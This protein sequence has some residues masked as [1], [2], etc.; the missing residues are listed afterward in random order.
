MNAGEFL[1]LTTAQQGIW[2]GQRLDPDSPAYNVGGYV[3]LRGVLDPGLLATACAVVSGEAETLRVRVEPGGERQVVLAEPGPGLSVVDVSG[4]PDPEAAASRSMRADL[5]RPSDPVREPV[6]VPVLYRLADHHHLWFVRCHHI[7]IDGYSFPLVCRRIAEVYTALARGAEPG[8]PPFAPLRLLVE[9]DL[10]YRESSERERDAGYWERTLAD[11]PPA[12]TLSGRRAAHTRAFTRHSTH[13]AD[14]AAAVLAGAAKASRTTWAEIAIAAFAAFQCRLTGEPVARIGIPTT[15]RVGTALL[16]VP[17]MAANV[18]PLVV[19]AAPERTGAEVVAAVATGLAGLRAHQRYRLEDLLRG[20]GRD[21]RDLYGP[22]VNIKFFDYGLDFAGVP[23]VFHNLAAGPVDD[24]TVSVYH[25]AGR[26]AVDLDANSETHTPAR[27]AGYGTRFTEFLTAFAAAPDLPVGDVELAEQRRSRGNGGQ[28]TGVPVAEAPSLGTAFLRTATAFPDRC[29]LRDGDRSWTFA[30]LAEETGHL[31]A[32]LR[33]AGARPD[34]VIGI[35]APRSAETVI[36][37]L[38]V[39]RAGA[40]WLPLDHELPVER[41]RHIVEQTAPRLMITCRGGATLDLAGIA[42]DVPVIDLDTVDLLAPTVPPDHVPPPDARAYVIH[43]SGSTGLPKGVHVSHRA[44]GTLLAAHGTG[45]F[46]R[47]PGRLRVAHTAPFAFDAAL[48]PVLWLVA[49]HELVVVGDTVSRDV[50]AL[51]DL[52]RRQRIDSLD[53]TPVHLAALVDAGL[54]AGEH[55]PRLVVFGGE[56]VPAPLW[57]TLAA[58]PALVAVNSYGPT[59]FTVDA[60]Q[61]V[62][63]GTEPVIGGPVGGARALVLDAR[64]RPVPAGAV[65][66]L[67]LGGP[68]LAR[69]YTGAAATAS[70]FVA[71]PLGPAGAR[72]YRTGDLV[73]LREDGAL[74]HLG[75]GDAQ[76]KLRGYRIEPGEVELALTAHP[77]VVRCAVV[78]RDDLLVAYA[79]TTAA[80]EDL[81]AH[82][83]TRLPHYLVPATIVPVATL[84]LTT[85]GKLDIAA[86][87]VPEPSTSDTEPRTATETVV[88]ALF[89]EVLGRDRVGVHDDF[90]ALGGHSLSAGRLLAALRAHTGVGLD[91]PTVL[92]ARTP[93]AL[94]RAVEDVNPDTEQDAGHPPL[95]RDSDDSPVPWS[96]AQARFLF[97]EQ[98]AG[99]SPVHHVP[100]VIRFPGRVAEEPLAAA[101]RDVVLRHEPLRTVLV[102]GHQ[103]VLPDA[104]VFTVRRVADEEAEIRALVRTPFDLT[105]EPPLRAT[106]L[107]GGTGDVLVLVSH[108][109]AADHGA[110]APLLA[111]LAHAY[112]TRAEGREPDWPPLAVRYRDHTR[113]HARLLDRTAGDHVAFW[114]ARLAGA[115]EEIP[116]PVDR[117][118][119]D[120]TTTDGA[121]A[122]RVLPAAVHQA[123]AECARA[124]GVTTFTVL[125]T[126]VALLLNRHGAGTDLPLGTPVDGRTEPALRDVVGCF[127]NTVV[128]RTDLS[129]TPTVRELLARVRDADAEALAHADLPFDRVT[130]AVNPPRVPGRHPLFQVLVVHEHATV[131]ALRLGDRTGRVELVNTGTAKVDLTIKFTERADRGGIAVFAEYAT[132]LF[133]EG[134][135]HALLA[136]LVTLL[137]ALTTGL[138]RPAAGLDVL[139]PAEAA[140][141]RRHAAGPRVP[142]EDTT[143]AGLLDRAVA[144]H[145]ARPALRFGARRLTY[146]EFDDRVTRLAAGLRDRGVGAGTVVAVD[147]PRSVELVVAL[148]AVVRAGAAYLPLD[149]DHPARRRE[150]MVTDA[151]P[152]LTLTAGLVRELAATPAR[153]DWR[154]ATP[155][156]PA[157]VIYTSGSTGRPKG[158]VVTHR[159][160]VNRLAWAQDTH[161]LGP[162][163]AVLHKTPAGFDVSVWELFWPL[164]HGAELVVAR[165]DGHRD[166][167]YL[168]AEIRATGVTTVHFVPSM[169][170]AFLTD[171]A[172]A[173]CTGLTRVLCSGEALTPDTAAAFRDVLPGVEL[174]NLYGP[175]EAAVDVTAWRVTDEPGPVPIGTP[176]WNT[177]V[178]V[179]DA[180]LRPVP[181]GV[182]GELYLAGRQ[183]ALGY[184]NRPGL[185]AE[186]FV[187]DPFG[188]PGT[189][190]YR[191]GDLARWRAGPLPG[192]LDYLGRTDFQVKVRGVRIEL[193]EV[194]AAL[195]RHPEVTA[196]AAAVHGTRLVGYVVPATVPPVAV[197][198]FVATVVPDALVPA[199]VVPLAALPLTPNGKLDRQALPAPGVTAPDTTRTGQVGVVRAAFAA[200]LG[201]ADVGADDGFFALGGD[202]ILA[203]DL[204][205]RVRAH[206][207]TV[208][209]RDVFAHQTP[210]ELA[211]RAAVVEAPAASRPAVGPVPL[212][213]MLHWL[214]DRDDLTATQSAEL[215]LPAGVTEESVVAAVRALMARHELLR[216]RLT[217]SRDGL[218]SLAVPESAEPVFDGTVDPTAGRTVVWRV[219]P[220]RLAVTAHHLAVDAVSWGVLAADLDALLAGRVLAPV[221]PFREWAD[222]QLERSAA[223]EVLDRFGYWRDVLAGRTPLP[224]GDTAPG[225]LEWTVQVGDLFRQAEER[226]RVTGGEL[227]VAAVV[228]ALGEV[229]LGVETHGRDDDNAGQVGWFTTLHPVHLAAP[230]P[231]PVAVLKHVKETLRTVPDPASYGLLR[232]LNPRTAPALA[233]LGDPELIVNHLGHRDTVLAGD[234]P[235]AAALE[236]TAYTT[237]DLHL[238][239]D[240]TGHDLAAFRTGLD[241]ALADLAVAVAASA[242]G[243]TPSDLT[244]PGLTQSDVD[245]LDRECPGWLDALPVTP[246]QEGLLAL[247]HTHPDALDVYTVEVVLRFAEPLDADRL[248]ASATR[249]VARHTAL[250]TGF[251]HLASGEAVGVLYPAVPVPVTT[252]TGRHTPFDLSAPPLVRF[253]LDA[254]TLTVTGHHLAWDGWS[255]PLLVRELLTLYVGGVVD[256]TSLPAHLTYLRGLGPPDL[257]VWREVLAGLAAPTLL[258]AAQP[259]PATE[260]PAEITAELDETRTEAV[261]ALARAH[262]LTVNTVV[263]GAWGLTLTEA[264][265]TGDVVFGVTVS[266]RPAGVPGIDTAIGMFVNTVPARFTGGD[267]ILA[268]LRHLQDTH[269]ATIDHQH[270]GLAAIQRALGLGPLFDTLVVVENYPLDEEALLAGFG[271]LRPIAIEADDATHYPVTLTV[272]PGPTLGV[273]LKYRRDALSEQDARRLLATFLDQL[274]R[275]VADPGARVEHHAATPA[276]RPTPT[277]L[278]AAGPTAARIATLFAETLALPEAGAGDSF[279]G[280]GGD[281]ILAIQLV[282]RARAAGLRFTAADVFAHRTP[283]ALAA[284]AVPHADTAVP[285]VTERGGDGLVPVMHALRELHGPIDGYAQQMLLRL[286]GDADEPRLRAAISAILARHPLLRSRLVTTPAWQLEPGEATVR[287]HRFDGD[288][289]AAARRLA[290]E[291]GVLTDWAWRAGELLV[292][293]HHLAV[294]GVSWRI[295]LDDLATVWAGREPYPVGTTFHQWA[296]LLAAEA[297][298]PR[299]TAELDHWRTALSAPPVLPGVVLDPVWDVAATQAEVSGTLGPADTTALL[300]EVADA[301]HTG[302]QELLL[303][304]LTSALGTGDVSVLL[305]G[306]GRADELF[307]GADTSRTVGWFTTL[308]PVRLPGATDLSTVVRQVREALRAVPDRGIGYGLL[309]HLNDTT[310]ADLAALPAPQVRFNYL[311]RL[312]AGTDRPFEPVD[313]REPLGGHVPPGLPVPH[314]LD[315]TVVV[316]D[317]PAGPVLRWRI[318][319]PA[320]RVAGD[321]VR[322]LAARFHTALTELPRL[323]ADGVPGGHTPSDFTLVHLAQDEID[324]FDELWRT[325]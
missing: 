207:L 293:I 188:P 79:V 215:P 113:W 139:A 260:L 18:L 308:Y 301:F 96:P 2:L 140:R 68:Q 217:V 192:P 72:L 37:M 31:A 185:T 286:P 82:L 103:R 144:E 119:G 304:A 40:A 280:L 105:T 239:L 45:L 259:G 146:A 15:D 162:G 263:R 213:P 313:T 85:N 145:P 172:A 320:E 55:R 77:A 21:V 222:R 159:A 5:A 194:E 27:T 219:L 289:S 61:A 115:P 58:T 190:L 216:A 310:A 325:S 179:L 63:T 73:R 177:D 176:V 230:G 305:E 134:T 8:A 258:V 126:A 171:P 298:A 149:P 150:L 248:A 28:L 317:V 25:G 295:L 238:R 199:V 323:A 307:P 285:T 233:A 137:A 43:T 99:P 120:T 270:T 299:R 228:L 101:I 237:R 242:G 84:P 163:D 272:F 86:L 245:D 183:L 98:L 17:G 116:L 100:L 292:T 252:A 3:D 276:P 131:D 277:P 161:P 83:R 36:A 284:I 256:D 206:G 314:P 59:E 267:T 279:F 318:A 226:F 38:A 54:L 254:S 269:A 189:R 109:T 62:V 251:R 49:G 324:E 106:M 265:G 135:A 7:A 66:E 160:V 20:G 114:R 33:D 89:A 220:G 246:L 14:D 127:V 169:L 255:A 240:S 232:H 184:L 42:P 193:G 107:R 102:D 282:A 187:A 64:L 224:A 143:L 130:E 46:T 221:R 266:G 24:V 294:D 250:R 309:R 53:L 65:G 19:D 121:V 205:N 108:H 30:E 223:P 47:F 92:T 35:V 312:T 142:V 88:C 94:A 129:G 148:H 80:Q 41:L 235:P 210:A 195:C 211:G 170:R 174:H 34:D 316:V 291:N 22:S 253:A 290:P 26:F 11:A 39:A 261:R 16:R 212:T 311:G 13:L 90:L 247:A 71:D 273:S 32:V 191:T 297:R 278:V 110:T 167:E 302:P 56:A 173:T 197:R 69:G 229:T 203:I 95:V 51:V 123:V 300:G 165:P 200:V 52:V 157:Y 141:L 198:E 175:T 75:R 283:A 104:D 231:D 303:A 321:V 60:T 186:R 97:A 112:A 182:A 133:D 236:L 164:A 136:R 218:W 274:D 296:G 48:D 70:R 57:H 178:R 319:W 81:L 287:P 152:V 275:C 209:V 155:A 132:A 29:A 118:R 23:G 138:D 306:H 6:F 4:E 125:R 44:L 322:D 204:V 10:A 122:G 249:L 241:R 117:P 50:D 225:S 288:T 12:T 208:G 257:D 196:A 268:A 87:P 244:R 234:A 78:V 124:A 262:G 201:V 67:Y 166:P 202:S 128:L 181:P 74:D 227:L 111:D 147:L 243:R 158:V 1:P 153:R 271:E 91:L 214:H 315:I 93:A 168:A 156:E 151:R 281:S 154:A 76:V 264:T 180:A 9:R